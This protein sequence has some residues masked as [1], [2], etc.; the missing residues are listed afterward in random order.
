MSKYIFPAVMILLNLSQMI[1]MLYRKD[2]VSAIYWLAAAV[3][4]LTVC[5][6]Q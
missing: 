1:V 2:F 5:L 4:N 3:L 6:K